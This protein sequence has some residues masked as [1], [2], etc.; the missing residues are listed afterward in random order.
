MKDTSQLVIKQLLP[1]LREK[2]RYIVFSILAEKDLKFSDVKKAIEFKILQYIGEV[3]YARAG[4][5][6]L[7]IFKKNTGIIKVSNKEVDKVKAAMAL[8]EKVNDEKVVF[9]GVY[10]SGILKKAKEKYFK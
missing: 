2:K 9:R 6:I 5:I 4:V 7:P 8:I 10:T 3:G 1:S